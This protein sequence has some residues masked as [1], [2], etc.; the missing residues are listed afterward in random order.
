LTAHQS[1]SHAK[2]NPALPIHHGLLTMKGNV[3]CHQARSTD[4]T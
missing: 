4:D 2:L 3:S 1:T